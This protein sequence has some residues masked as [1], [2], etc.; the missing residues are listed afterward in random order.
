MALKTYKPITP[1]L[2]QLVIVDRKGLWKGKPVKALTQGKTRT[3]G[4][5]NHGRI[6][7]HH[8]GGGH[9]QRLRIVDFK[10]RKVDIA[11]TVE[12]LEYDPN[13]SAF[14]A[15]IKY[16]DGELA[17][18]LAPQRLKAGDEVVSGERVDIKPGNAM[19]LANMPVGTIV[20]NVE[21]KKGAGGKLARS[22]GTY[23]QLVGKDAGYAQIKLSSGELRLVSA[24]CLATVGAVSNPDNQNIVIGKA[25]RQ[26]WLG[27]RPHVRGVAMNPVDHPHGGGE[28]KSSG[29]RHPVTPWGKPTKGKKTRKNKATDKYII[30]RRRASR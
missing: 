30:R 5:N 21:L 13:R 26:R 25:G 9:K 11:A 14:I 28:G 27:R 3:G 29:G 10:R 12:R 7:S 24:E 4:R 2:R 20:H 8:M 23:A 6:T 22:A 15:L 17:Y 18:I 1:S 16:A 19:P